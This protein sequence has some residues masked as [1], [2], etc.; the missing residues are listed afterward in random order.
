[1]PLPGGRFLLAWTQVKVDNVAA[2]SN[3]KAR[4]FSQAGPVGQVTQFNTT[5]GGQRFSL[6]AA[7]TNS[8]EGEIAF[9]AWTDERQT[10]G[11]TSGRAVR[12]RPLSIP[13]AGF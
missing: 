13:A 12:G 6:S 7:A 8:L 9:A 10:A 3:V 1:V 2:G 11:D 4:I 5:T